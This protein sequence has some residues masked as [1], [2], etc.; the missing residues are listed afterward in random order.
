MSEACR[1]CQRRQSSASVLPAAR[2]LPI[3]RRVWL[4]KAE[5]RCTHAPEGR[6]PGAPRCHESPVFRA[7][8]PFCFI[9]VQAKING[10]H[11]KQID[12]CC[13]SATD[14]E[15][16]LHTNLINTLFTF[17]RLKTHYSC[18]S[19]CLCVCVCAAGLILLSASVLLRVNASAQSLRNRIPPVLQTQTHT[20]SH[21]QIHTHAQTHTKTGWYK[22]T[23]AGRMH[24]RTQAHVSQLFQDEWCG[25]RR[26][27]RRAAHELGC[28]ERMGKIKK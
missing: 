7:F 1:R 23:Q 24:G 18:L 19:M 4:R 22:N 9:C 10:D 17:A 20:H 15:T 16:W 12:G 26:A 3:W 6:R 2:R 5:Q 13:R 14:M 25:R 21:T 11:R 28:G 27:N 8:L